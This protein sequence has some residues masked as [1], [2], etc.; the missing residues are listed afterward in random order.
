[1]PQDVLSTLQLLLAGSQWCPATPDTM[2]QLM[3]AG[4]QALVRQEDA[5]PFREPV[6][7]RGCARL[8]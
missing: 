1:M 6:S 4:L 2:Q 3:E 5:W 7:P 8:P